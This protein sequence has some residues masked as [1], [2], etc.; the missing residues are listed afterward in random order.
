MNGELRM[1][2]TKPKRIHINS[3]TIRSNKKHGTTN[4]AVT[5][6]IGQ[7]VIGYGHEVVIN[8][9]SKVVYEPENPLVCGARVWIETDA[10]V[11]LLNRETQETRVIK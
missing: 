6:R 2:L 4:P 1:S 7:K 10:T 3:N 9:P 11:E 8:G 5:V